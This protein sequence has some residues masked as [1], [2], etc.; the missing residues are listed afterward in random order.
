M[1]DQ[2]VNYEDTRPLQ[3]GLVAGFLGALL[4]FVIQKAMQ[5]VTGMP[6]MGEMLANQWLG[7]YDAQA[8][9]LGLLLFGLAGATWGA[10]YIFSVRNISIAT[11][12]MYGLVPWLAV[13]LIFD[14]L[15]RGNVFADGNPMGI[16]APLVLN[17]IWGAFVGALV[18]VLPFR[19]QEWYNDYS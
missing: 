16:L 6:P 8:M 4:L 7:V 5:G 10:F 13:M 2:E 15:T 11:G 9:A 14:P 18:P 1:K 19:R 3:A 17:V 12:A